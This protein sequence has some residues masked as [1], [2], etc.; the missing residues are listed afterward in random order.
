VTGRDSFA[1]YREALAAVGFRPSSSLGQNFLLD[2]SLHRFIA[3]TAAPG[4]ADTALEIGVGLGFLTRELACRA[5][6]VLGVEIDARLLQ[7]VGAELRALG[8][9]QL[10]GVDALGGSGGTLHPEVVTALASGPGELFVFATLPYAVSGPLLA[11]LCQL[12]VLP[13]CMVVLVQ[14]E[15]GARLAAAPGTKDYGSLAALLQNL[16]TVRSVRD[17]PPQVFRPRPKVM[18]AIVRC[19]RLPPAPGL[20]AAGCR[21]RFA[22]FLR[23]LFQQRRKTLNRTLHHTAAGMG[24]VLPRLAPALLLRRAESLTPVELRQL[25]QQVDP[26]GK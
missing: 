5:G 13:A 19:Q 21:S 6:L 24:L 25:W 9:V 23:L 12:P 11:E 2:Q 3:E 16:F 20:E 17:V 7:V 14:K 4:P 18:S 1:S 15:L 10:L 22:R 26:A 8:N